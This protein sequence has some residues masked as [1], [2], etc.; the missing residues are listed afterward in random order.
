MVSMIR[1]RVGLLLVTAM[2]AVYGVKE[3]IEAVRYGSPLADGLEAL[4]IGAATLAG[5]AVL[6]KVSRRDDE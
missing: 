3:L 1:L 6:T 5:Y 4:A 2:F